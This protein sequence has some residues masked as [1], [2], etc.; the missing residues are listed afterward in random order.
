MNDE[1][2]KQLCLALMRAD[3][4]IEIIKL[5]TNAGFWE[6]ADAWRYYGD[7]ENNYTRLISGSKGRNTAKNSNA[8]A[9]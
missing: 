2:S 3:L 1:T 8:I 9:T 7:Y 5:L 4:E 6:N